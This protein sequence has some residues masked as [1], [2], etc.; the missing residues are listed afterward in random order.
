MIEMTRCPRPERFHLSVHV[1][2]I[3]SRER[4]V[5]MVFSAD[6]NQTLVAI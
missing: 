2:V 1:T 6:F 3:P 4:C 5:K